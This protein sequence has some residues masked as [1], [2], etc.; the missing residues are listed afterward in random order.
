[1]TLIQADWKCMGMVG[2]L[3]LGWIFI[4]RQAAY[5]RTKK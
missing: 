4:D 2:D 1:M 3:K 5:Q